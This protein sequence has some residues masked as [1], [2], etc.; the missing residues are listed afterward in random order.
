MDL[1]ADDEIVGAVTRDL[2]AR[3]HAIL[4]IH[5][6]G[7]T[8]EAHV[9]ELLR[10][11]DPP[12]GARV[13]DI[14]CGT[15]AVAKLMAEARPDLRFTLLNVSPSQLGMCPAGFDLICGDMNDLPFSSGSFDA[16]MALYALGHG[17]LAAVTGEIER[18]LR[19]GGVAFVYDLAADEPAALEEALNY[20]AHDLA[21]IARCG[22]VMETIPLKATSVERFM[23]VM[24]LCAYRRIFAGVS[25]VAYRMRKP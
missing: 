14:G 4:Q 11:F 10:L 8:D 17:D 9:A 3:G 13:L 2:V 21:D 1:Y 15:G 12:Q 6:L 16:V 24:P 5:R 18:V 19:P 20:R 23:E 25:P 7:E 22:M